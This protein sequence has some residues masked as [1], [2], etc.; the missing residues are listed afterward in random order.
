[1]GG[2]RIFDWGGPRIEKAQDGH[3]NVALFALKSWSIGGA[4]ALWP[5]P[6]TALGVALLPGFQPA[7]HEH[8]IREK[9]VT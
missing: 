9:L 7:A 4:M 6:G 8:R 1:M 3:Q 5:P 2:S